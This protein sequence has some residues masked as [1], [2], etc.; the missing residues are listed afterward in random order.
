[1]NGISNVSQTYITSFTTIFLA[2]EYYNDRQLNVIYK[3][4]DDLAQQHNGNLNVGYLFESEIELR[5]TNTSDF[6]FLGLNAV[7]WI[8]IQF[9]I[10][11]KY[12]QATRDF[13]TNKIENVWI[14][15]ENG[16]IL[17][18]ESGG[19]WRFNLNEDKVAN[20]M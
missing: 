19:G 3:S 7:D 20:D 8:P 6:N 11:V 5:Q 13:W 18:F 12:I 1:M 15:T 17:F 4:S 16:Q 2:V 10:G 9:T 14:L